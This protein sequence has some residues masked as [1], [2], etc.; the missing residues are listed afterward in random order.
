VIAAEAITTRRCEGR[1][2]SF[3][4]AGDEVEVE[5]V[6]TTWNTQYSARTT[7]CD[8]ASQQLIFGTPGAGPN[9]S[10]ALLIAFADTGG[11]AGSS[12]KD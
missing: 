9:A 4:L 8:E 3:T 1:G 7:N 11:F 12:C 5:V 6:L 10:P 2:G